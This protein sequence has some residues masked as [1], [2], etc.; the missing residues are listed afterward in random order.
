MTLRE[1]K[2]ADKEQCLAIFNSNCP[3]YF[4]VNEYGL[5]E[6]WLD[7]QVDES[8]HYKCP[9]YRSSEKEA[10]FVM[11]L[12]YS[13]LVGCGGFYIVKDEPEVR[14]AWGMI[15]ADFHKQGYGTAL[16]EYRKKILLRDWSYH[17]LTLGTSQHTFGF[18]EK[19]GLTVIDIVKSGYG[20]H[21]DRYDMKIVTPVADNF[22]DKVR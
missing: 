4:D 20:P 2:S 6:N 9:T 13:R 12:P 5:F 18:Y 10:Y 21:L 17:V 22:N 15:H 19:M 7:H 3:N 14:L 16:F 11:E 1:Y 8:T